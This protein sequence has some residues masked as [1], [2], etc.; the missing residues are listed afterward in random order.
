M[1]D[2]R[3]V[4][5]R[6]RDM[7]AGFGRWRCPIRAS[8]ASQRGLSGLRPLPPIP[9]RRTPGSREIAEMPTM[10]LE[11]SRVTTTTACERAPGRRGE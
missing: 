10:A 7:N 5:A 1:A 11:E 6:E 2:L 9:H 4:A 8:V 3:L